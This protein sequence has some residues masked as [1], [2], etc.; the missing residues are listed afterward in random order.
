MYQL[1]SR[2]L[3]K[4]KKKNQNYTSWSK[5]WQRMPVRLLFPDLNL[6]QTSKDW[7]SLFL[8]CLGL[9]A[10]RV[11]GFGFYPECFHLQ[12]PGDMHPGYCCWGRFTCLGLSVSCTGCRLSPRILWSNAGLAAGGFG[13]VK[14]NIPLYVCDYDWCTA[15]QI[16]KT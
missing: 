5:L 11:G 3:K 4:K 9:P 8:Y 15:S 16:H 6:W 13:R 10:F 7:A 2:V 12:L 1:G 14:T